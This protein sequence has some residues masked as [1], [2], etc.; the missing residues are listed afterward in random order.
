MGR[1]FVGLKYL[2]VGTGV[3][4]LLADPFRIVEMARAA[5]TVRQHLCDQWKPSTPYSK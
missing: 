2:G 1:K 4:G 5:P 3:G